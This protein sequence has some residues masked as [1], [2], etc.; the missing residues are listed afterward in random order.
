MKIYIEQLPLNIFCNNHN[1]EYYYKLISNT[2]N[3]YSLFRYVG[4]PIMKRITKRKI[5]YDIKRSIYCCKTK[6][7]RYSKIVQTIDISEEE[8][9][10]LLNIKLSLIRDLENTGTTRSDST[11]IKT[12]RENINYLLKYLN[13]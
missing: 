10:E 11:I 13:P 6:S 1:N 2:G 9:I 7:S 8:L 3:E 12:S 4:S 5:K